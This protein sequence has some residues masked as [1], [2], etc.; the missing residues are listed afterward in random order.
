MKTRLWYI[1]WSLQI[2]GLLCLSGG[3]P[4][5]VTRLG[6]ACRM[7][8]LIVLEPGFLIMQ[9]LIEKTLWGFVAYRGSNVLVGGLF[10]CRI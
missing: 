7:I 10:S 4:C 1:F 3:E 6:F 5:A 9:T 2:I 8:A